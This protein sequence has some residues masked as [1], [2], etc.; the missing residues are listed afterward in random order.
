MSTCCSTF[1]IIAPS[2]RKELVVLCMLQPRLQD[3]DY[4]TRVILVVVL[5]RHAPESDLV[6]N[7]IH[8]IY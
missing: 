8:I 1:N 7:K 3:L 2:G 6:H 5:Q 4:L